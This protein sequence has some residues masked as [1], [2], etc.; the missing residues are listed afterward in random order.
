MQQI[1]WNSGGGGELPRSTKLQTDTILLSMVQPSRSGLP[2][3]RL[4]NGASVDPLDKQGKIFDINVTYVHKNIW[5]VIY[6]TP[7]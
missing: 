7:Q 1:T 4:Q 6:L 5:A 2:L 3:K